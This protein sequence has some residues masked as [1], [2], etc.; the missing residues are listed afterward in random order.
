ME[1]ESQE[2]RFLKHL[3]EE[4]LR[5]IETRTK[6]TLQK[7]AFV[8]GLMGL[9]SLNITVGKIDFSYLVYLAP[10]V[11][12]A[13]DFYIM[14]EDYS[15]KRIGAFLKTLSL[16]RS[17]RQWEQWVADN[18][19]PFA[20]WAM[21]MLTTLIFLG[22]ALIAYQ[23]PG[24]TQELPFKIWLVLTGLPSWLSFVHY[25]RLRKR[26]LKKAPQAS[27]QSVFLPQVIR[28]VEATDHQLTD[29]TYREISRLFAECQTNSSSLQEIQES[30]REYGNQEFFLCVNREGESAPIGGEILD[31]FDQTIARY[32]EY[33]LWFH[34]AKFPDDQPTLLIARWLCH[35]VGFRHR[36]VHLFIDHPEL[37]DHTLIQ[38]RSLDKAES[39]G[40][41]DLPAAGHVTGMEK[42]EAAL[43]KELF[44]ELGLEV[45]SLTGLTQL[46]SYTFSDP[47]GF[48]NVEYRTVF[49]GRLS[50]DDWLKVSANSD[51]VT[52]IVSLPIIKLHEMIIVF[53]DPIASGL[54]A[55][56][57]LYLKHKLTT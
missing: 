21:P 39:P 22:A 35:L 44:E 31:D 37:V 17:E 14:G 8:T 15:V 55:S 7:L 2:T 36:V 10:W 20:P 40:R 30:T 46:G 57:P 26:V 6:Y 23:Q 47:T 29:A 12:I 3:H 41:F 5:I 4:K 51:E 19:D 18:R 52:A 16:A 9:G 32:P 38:V 28:A 25:R 56:F 13:F 48:H 33:S 53:P 54:M 43:H 49:F 1:D 45:K 42:V 34:K 50:A 27:G 24:M 11:A